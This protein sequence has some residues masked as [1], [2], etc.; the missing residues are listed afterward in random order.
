MKN[1]LVKLAVAS[2]LTASMLLPMFAGAATVDELIA[3]LQQQIATLKAQLDA[4]RQAQQAVQ[5]TQQ[6]V[7]GTIKLIVQLNEGSSVDQ[8][9]LLQ[10][11]LAADPTLFPEGLITGFYGRLTALA[12]KRF[13][14]KFGIEQ[15]G[16]VGPKTLEKL[17]KE[18]L[19]HN[20][21]EEDDE[22]DDDNDGDRHEKKFCIPSGHL[23]APGWLKKIEREGNDRRGGEHGMGNIRDITI[24]MPCKN[25]S[26]T[27]P[28]ATPTPTPTPTPTATPTLDT[29]APVI[30][31]VTSS[32]ITSVSAHISWTTNEAATSRAWYGTVTPLATSTA[33]T[34]SDAATITAH[35]FVLSTLSASTTYYYIVSSADAAGNTAN[36]SENSFTTTQ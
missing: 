20:L 26:S 36:S 25:A 35:E 4:L 1:N 30:S 16:R 14:K 34:I 7:A 19:K 13:Q 8:V 17:N 9:K 22:D 18:L 5:T 3:T 15:V 27:P 33:L 28:A 24:V 29:T 10:T 11:L 21:K 31:T 23:I 32:A 6:S 12:V 2:V